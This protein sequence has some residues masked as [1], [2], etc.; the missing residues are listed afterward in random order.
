MSNYYY[1]IQVLN[2]S[3]FICFICQCLLFVLW[4]KVFY[5]KILARFSAVMLV[6]SS[7]VHAGLVPN[8]TVLTHRVFLFLT[9][10]H[11]AENQNFY[12]ILNLFK[13]NNSLKPFL[14]FLEVLLFNFFSSLFFVRKPSE[15]STKLCTF[16]IKT[17]S[18]MFIR[19]FAILFILS[20]KLET[21]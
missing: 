20:L 17:C 13:I 19:N 21:F 3:F 8:A 12:K 10:L 5:F 16:F 18:Y 6:F 7:K 1:S 4:Y 2:T 15:V 11:I 9:R 14:L